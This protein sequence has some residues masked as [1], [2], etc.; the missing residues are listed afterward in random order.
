MSHYETLGVSKDADQDEIKKAYR[1]LA[2]KHH[3]DKGGDP[4]VFKNISQAY[5]TLSDEDKRRM[6]DTAPNGMPDLS[7]MF[8]GF[9]PFGG[10]PPKRVMEYRIR[11]T[12]ED[13]YNER[14]KTLKIDWDRDCPVCTTECRTCKGSG[15]F[16]K[17]LG[18][19]SIQQPCASCQGVGKSAKG[20][21]E[22][23][24]QK[25]IRDT[26]EVKIDIGGATH[27]GE[28]VELKDMNVVLV[29]EIVP[30]PHF[31]RVD[32]DLFYTCP[33]SFIDSIHGTVIEVPHFKETLKISTQDFG[34]LDPRKYYKVKGKGMKGG[35]LNIQFDIKYPDP[36]ERYEINSVTI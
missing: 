24:N 29:F 28:R 3:P 33:I 17:N 5:E 4:E 23:K 15:M 13:V 12:L 8:A 1:K 20:C 7:Q 31:R 14:K 9:N 16:A 25:K 30:H 27:S 10:P 2:M 26:K 34:V 18:F 35:D 22:C 36:S 21:S 19:M 6:Y 32:Q 11:F